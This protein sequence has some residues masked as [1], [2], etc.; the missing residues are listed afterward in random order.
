MRLGLTAV[1]AVA[2][3]V[4]LV[5]ERVL[6]VSSFRLAAAPRVGLVRC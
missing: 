6:I 5:S 2:V 4:L 1:A 3:V